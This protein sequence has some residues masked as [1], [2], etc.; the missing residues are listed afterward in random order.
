MRT[1][2]AWAYYRYTFIVFIPW[3]CIL[4]AACYVWKRTVE[5]F[6]LQFS[7]GA[8]KTAGSFMGVDV[9]YKV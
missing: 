4:I 8:E 1:I 2:L 3:L 6:A 9:F 7:R 5:E